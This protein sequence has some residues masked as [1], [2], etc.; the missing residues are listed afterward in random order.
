MEFNLDVC[1]VLV[2]LG[3]QC[4]LFVLKCI[5]GWD[6]VFFLY[7]FNNSVKI[8]GS[9]VIIVYLF[10]IYVGCEGLKKL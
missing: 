1:I 4:N 10:N 3:G 8:E 9:D 5:L 2:F 6:R 7:D